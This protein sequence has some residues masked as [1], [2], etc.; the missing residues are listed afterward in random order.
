MQ[1]EIGRPMRS[2]YDLPRE[3][4]KELATSLDRLLALPRAAAAEVE[5]RHR[6]RKLL[7]RAM[8]CEEAAGTALNENIKEIYLDLAAQWRD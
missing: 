7:Q 6:T 4:P 5:P 8:A 2:E 1:T 3:L